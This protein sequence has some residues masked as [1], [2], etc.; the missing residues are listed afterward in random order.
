[1]NAL[2]N[3]VIKIEKKNLTS[4]RNGWWSGGTSLKKVH[5]LLL[6]LFNFYFF[7]VLNSGIFASKFLHG[8]LLSV[9]IIVSISILSISGVSMV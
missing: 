3:Y 4:G 9:K 7:K 6:I 1:M 5:L 2:S 8:S